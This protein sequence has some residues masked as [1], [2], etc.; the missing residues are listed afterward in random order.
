MRKVYWVRFRSKRFFAALIA[1]IT[2]LWLLSVESRSLLLFPLPNSSFSVLLQSWLSF[3]LSALEALIFLAVG[4]LVWLFARDRLVAK[5]LFGFSF[6]MMVIF[7]TEITS[8]SDHFLSTLT[9]ICSSLALLLLSILLLLFP[10]N[11]LLWHVP[12]GVDSTEVGGHLHFNQRRRYYAIRL[13]YG[14]LGIL[15][16][17]SFTMA[18]G[19]ILIFLLAIKL[20]D[21]LNTVENIYF[22]VGL[23]GILLTIIVSYRQSSSLRARQQF[24]IFLSGVLLAFAPF[25]L[26][27]ILPQALNL[28]P[29]YI[30]DGQISTITLALFP[31]ALGYTILRY[32]I[33][34][35]DMYVRRAV[36]WVVGSINLAFLICLVI[37]LSSVLLASNVTA[38]VVIVAIVMAVLGPCVWWLAHVS[39]ERLFFSEIL[40]YR[41]LLERPGMLANETIDLNEASRL[42]T[43]AAVNTFETQEVCIL[44]LDDDTGYYR[45]YPALK[46]DDPADASRRSLVQTLLQVARPQA[47]GGREGADGLEADEPLLERLALA[48]RPLLLS[49]AS[50]TDEELPTGLARYLTTTSPLDRSDPL[51]APVLAQGKMIGVLVLGERGD[52]Q[53]YA[54]PDFEAIHLIFVRFSPV[55]ETARLYAQ[56]SRHVAILNT[57]YGA[58]TM[59]IEAFETLEEVATVYTKV[60]AEAVMAGAEIWLYHEAELQLRCVTHEGAGPP[61]VTLDTLT[62]SPDMDWSTWFYQGES[63]EAGTSIDAP[64]CLPE[65]PRFP[66]AWIPLKQGQAQIGILTLMYPRPHLFSHEEKRVLEM[67]ASQ[68]AAALENA[69]I[70]I[71]LRAAYE[72]QKELDQL[73]DQF[74]VTASHELRTPLTA[75]VGY[76]ELLAAYNSTLA[77]DV[78]ADFIAKAHRGCD[79]L[80]LMVGNI[81]DA[82]RV[83]FDE[84]NISLSGVPLAESVQHVLEIMEA[85]TRREGRAIQVDISPDVLVMADN[86]RL[87][88]VLLNIVSNALKYSPQGCGIEI[89]MDM[90][91][92]QV[93]VYVQDHGLGVPLEEQKHL[94]ERFVRLE[95]DMNSPVRGAGLG[96]FISKQLV[97]AMDGRIWVESTGVSGEGSRF[98]FTLKRSKPGEDTWRYSQLERQEV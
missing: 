66:F 51:L 46:D 47:L 57:L 86:V 39:T 30:V 29:Q 92:K 77:P 89:T 25:L 34:V 61:L 52:H 48:T 78:R 15:T 38:S 68:C 80:T 6:A 19:S 56:A 28:P 50:K 41:R 13:R 98:A 67:F 90:D 40:H 84:E 11:Y 26:L 53:Q 96:L 1:L 7:A 4:M 63:P 45:L 70:T 42:L 49:E 20:P 37:A 24:R 18:I 9:T 75:V 62:P 14:Y 27:T 58:S 64:P 81:M 35:F 21:W 16:L 79:E 97:E 72:R 76:I 32:Q 55:L 94:F 33:L 88:Q 85:I 10:K 5:V 8:S 54:G 59:P 83:Q 73:K 74:I 12:S 36:A 93:T 22:L 87:R 82:S 95:R 3:G 44:V 23:I 71:E 31:L 60:A 43:L 65:T 2:Y 69:R 17:L 91:E